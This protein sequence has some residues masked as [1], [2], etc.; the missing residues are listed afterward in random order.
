MISRS[1]RRAWGL[2][3]GLALTLTA[4]AVAASLQP[5][6][7][8]IAQR[9]IRFAQPQAFVKVGDVIRY[10]NQ[11]DVTHNLMVIGAD[12]IPQDQGLQPP[13]ALVS[14]KFNEAGTFEVRCAIHPKMKMTVT[15]TQ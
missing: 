4:T 2:V 9:A 13:G 5:V 8:D 14:H 10:H 1:Q 3:G 11:D 7:R 12:D 15:V 6:V